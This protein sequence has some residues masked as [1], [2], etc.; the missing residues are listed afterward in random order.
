M[1][2]PAERTVPDPSGDPESGLFWLLHVGNGVGPLGGSPWG[3]ANEAVLRDVPV[4]RK[5]A[6]A[7]SGWCR[8]PQRVE[9]TS[10]LVLVRGS[11]LTCRKGWDKDFWEPIARNGRTVDRIPRGPLLGPVPPASREDI[12]AIIKAGKYSDDERAAT[13]SVEEDRVVGAAPSPLTHVPKSL[14]TKH[15]PPAPEQAQ[16]EPGS[17]EGPNSRE[18]I[19]IA[20]EEVA[21]KRISNRIRPTFEPL[22]S[23][24]VLPVS[25]TEAAPERSEPIDA[26]PVVPEAVPEN[27][28]DS[29]VDDNTVAN[30]EKLPYQEERQPLPF[31][32]RPSID[33]WDDEPLVPSIPPTFD[34]WNY[35]EDRHPPFLWLV[36]GVNSKQPDEAEVAFDSGTSGRAETDDVVAQGNLHFDDQPFELPPPV[37]TSF[38][39]PSRPEREKPRSRRQQ[40]LHTFRTRWADGRERPRRQAPVP[41]PI[42]VDAPDAVDDP[43]WPEES[44]RRTGIPSTEVV[45]PALGEREAGVPLVHVEMSQLPPAVTESPSDWAETDDGSWIAPVGGLC[46]AGLVRDRGGSG[47]PYSSDRMDYA[48]GRPQLR[49][50]QRLR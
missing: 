14:I 44:D 15:L 21:R 20:K 9:A 29:V 5:G 42:W 17:D 11:Q 30:D 48:G 49:Q 24:P 26:S 34:H 41:Q 10:D 27:V 13:G 35:P 3:I 47:C 23:A 50:R 36:Q 40:Q 19:L 31:D 6:L 46:A 32:V 8:N 12:D 37:E 33:E 39:P 45:L 43:V 2:L 22:P 16:A 1:S 4:L 18:K 28:V 38:Q 25:P 7:G